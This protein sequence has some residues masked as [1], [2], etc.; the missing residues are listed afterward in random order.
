MIDE[1]KYMYRCLQLAAF[2]AGYVA[3]NPMVGAILVHNGKIIAEGFHRKYGES[4]AEPNAIYAVKDE[5]LLKE[6]TLYV[7][8]EPCSFYGKTPPCAD[9]IVSKGIPKVVI[10]TLDPNP[11]VSGRGVEILRNAGI[12]VTV[13][14]LEEACN[15]LNKRFFIWQKERRPYVLIKWA[16]TRDGF[17]DVVRTDVTTPPLQI[18]NNITKQLTHKIRSEYQS[19]MVSTNTV[20]LDNPSLT[21]RRWAG[22]N[23]VRLILDRTGRIPANYH[24]FDDAVKTIIFTENPKTNTEKTEFVNITYD[25]DFLKNMLKQIAERNIHS[26]LVEGGSQLLNSFITSGLWDEANVEISN[27]IIAAGVPAPKLDV[28]VERTSSFDNHLWLNYKNRKI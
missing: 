2:G 9:L 21:V 22:K 1:E 12:D 27:Q 13:G 17:I 16:Q 3:P 7:N 23:P 14:L 20:V 8:L 18:S 24:I 6:S 10:G 28:Q 5:K 26:V 25:Q 15:E 19:I 11:K 4:H